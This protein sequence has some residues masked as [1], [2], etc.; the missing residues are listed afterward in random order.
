MLLKY[1]EEARLIIDILLKWSDKINVKIEPK[2]DIFDR[3]TYC[4]KGFPNELLEE[5]NKRWIEYDTKHD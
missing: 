3:L 4:M 1:M 5:F 2:E